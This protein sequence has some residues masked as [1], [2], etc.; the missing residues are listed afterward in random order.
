MLSQA[1]GAIRRQRSARMNGLNS[2][3]K[4]QA[5]APEAARTR[6]RPRDTAA[7]SAGEA[8]SQKGPSSGVVT[9]DLLRPACAAVAQWA[10][11]SVRGALAVPQRARARPQVLSNANVVLCLP[12]LAALQNPAFPV[13][14]MSSAPPPSWQLE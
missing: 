8:S 3:V 2:A 1:L 13:S 5:G 6:K 7:P 12:S 14:L 9:D 10:Q 4:Q 11:V